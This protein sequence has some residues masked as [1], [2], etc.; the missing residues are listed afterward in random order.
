MPKVYQYPPETASQM[1]LMLKSAT[2][3]LTFRG[4]QC[5]YLQAR[6]SY[7]PRQIAEITGLKTHKVR[8]ILKAY[9]ERGEIALKEISYRRSYLSKAE[10]SKILNSF[11]D[12]IVAG[13]RVKLKEIHKRYEEVAQR[14]ISRAATYKLLQRHG[15]HKVL[16]HPHNPNQEK[17]GIKDVKKELTQWVPASMSSLD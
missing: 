4:V 5:V 11:N 13:N 1:E 10:E 17:N 2:D 6:F 7:V 16:L 9:K 8:K 14:N 15:W 12:R 3:L